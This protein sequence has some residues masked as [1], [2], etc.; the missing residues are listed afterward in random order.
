MLRLGSSKPWPE[1]M[2]EITGQQHMDA[3]PIIDYFQ[4][5]IDWLKDQNKGDNPGWSQTCSTTKLSR[6]LGEVDTWLGEY[7]KK[8]TLAYN[9][10]Y[11]AEWAYGSNINAQ[12][13]AANVRSY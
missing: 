8:A 5:L 9:K 11:E 13:T 12:T 10:D 4:P 1:A 6:S 3:K 2:R 7:E